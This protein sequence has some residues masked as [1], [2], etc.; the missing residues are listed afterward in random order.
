M[1]VIIFNGCESYLREI[2]PDLVKFLFEIGVLENHPFN[3]PA[4]MAKTHIALAP[5]KG[6][7][8]MVRRDWFDC[9][10]ADLQSAKRAWD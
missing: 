3:L 6:H 10:E 5:N 1:K 9:T 8:V 2:D 4:D 7:V